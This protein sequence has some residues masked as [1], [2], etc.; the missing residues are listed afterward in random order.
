MGVF[1]YVAVGSRHSIAL[2]AHMPLLESNIKQNCVE[3][4]SLFMLFH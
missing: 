4:N 3:N 2:Y 1:R